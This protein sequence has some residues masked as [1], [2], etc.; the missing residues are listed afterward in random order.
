[1]HK[2]TRL[3][4]FGKTTRSDI[5]AY[6][7]SGT[8]WKSHLNV[9]GKHVI[10]L[11]IWEF[12]DFEQA[13]GFAL[14]FSID[15]QIRTSKAWA[16]LIDETALDG[17]SMPGSLSKEA[18]VRIGIARS[19]M[20]GKKWYND[21]SKTIVSAIHPGQGWSLGRL[22]DGDKNSFYGL[23]HT[24]EIKDKIASAKRGISSPKINRDGYEK[25]T[26]IVYWTNGQI[27]T[28]SNLGKF[29]RIHDL[30]LNLSRFTRPNPPKSNTLLRIERHP[31]TM[32]AMSL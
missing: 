24:Q 11:R 17:G 26:Y 12:T 10:T 4:Y 28:T 31:K 32:D 30:K 14:K 23:S 5:D 18:R 7:G 20:T 19:Q 21:G 2:V 9:H 6:L 8:Y 13:K 22:Y 15:N 29:A 1:M 3:K 25:Y 16:N 27:D